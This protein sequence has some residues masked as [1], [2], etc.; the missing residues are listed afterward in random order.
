M[1]PRV[2]VDIFNLERGV[3]L[4]EDHNLCVTC[5]Y[6]VDF[7]ETRNSKRSNDNEDVIIAILSISMAW[8]PSLG[9]HV[10]RALPKYTRNYYVK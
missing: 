5:I 3:L 4:K 2:L 8:L 10:V 9:Q 7:N 6:T 1:P